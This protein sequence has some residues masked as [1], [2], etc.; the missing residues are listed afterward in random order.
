[1]NQF[2]TLILGIIIGYAL[3]LVLNIITKRKEYS[4]IDQQTQE[5]EKN[6]E[7]VINFLETKDILTN[8]KVEQLLG[9]SNSTT[10]RYLDELETRGLIRQVGKTGKYTHYERV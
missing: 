2:F 6:I 7:K 8:D 5:K 4:L 10:T 9:V 3:G 1:M